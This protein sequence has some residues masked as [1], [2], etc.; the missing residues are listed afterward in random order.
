MKFETS[1]YDITYSDI[2]NRLISLD[3]C[4]IPYG[5]WH[6]TRLSVEKIKKYSSFTLPT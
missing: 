3:Q 6:C 5:I 2:Q 1:S 4:H